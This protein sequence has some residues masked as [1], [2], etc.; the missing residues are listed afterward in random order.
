MR[1]TQ[2]P[3]FQKHLAAAAPH[4][5]CRVY[6]ISCADAFERKGALD[7]LLSVAASP[8]ALVV[9]SSGAEMAVRE[10]LDALN[11]PRLFGGEPI[12]VV[13]EV[14]KKFHDALSSWFKEPPA[15]GY[16]FLGS[17]GKIGGS[18][19]ETHGVVLDLTEEKPWDK[20][21][22]LAEKLQGM[23]K[24]AGMRLNGDAL[25]LI[26]ERLECDAA[27]LSHE[28]EK[29]ICYA[30]GKQEI[31]RADV[32]AVCKSNRSYTLW[33]I[34]DDLIWERIFRA[35][36]A[37]LSDPSFFHGL[38]ASLRQ[39]LITG[40][41]MCSLRQAGIPFGE[42]KPHFP[43]LWAKALEKKA[44]LSAKLGGAY[45]RKGLDLL[46]QIDLLSKSGSLPP[47][48]LLDYFRLKL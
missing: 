23:A 29:L 32:E 13:D 16:L 14:D 12:V 21:K 2:L 15:F 18:F 36:T 35:N 48:A 34:A 39:Q 46:F 22:R 43:K 11:S 25:A 8:D 5:L 30:A 31:S 4:N 24:S 38:L 1:Y 20:E 10:I 41:K 45:F 17:K 40:E 26:L 42:W 7:A 28:M 19:A 9:R 37:E 33:Q 47:D 44:D 27:M 6:L 3:A